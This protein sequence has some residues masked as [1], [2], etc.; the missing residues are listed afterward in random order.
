MCIVCKTPLA[1]SQSPEAERERTFISGLIAKGE[2]KA[3]ILKA[4]VVQYGPAVLA[5]PP[6]HGFNLTIYV[7]PAGAA[8]H[9]R[10]D[11]A[12]SRSHGGAGEREPPTATRPTPPS[13]R[14]R[15][16]TRTGSKKT[17]PGT[18]ANTCYIDVRR[19]DAEQP[20]RQRDR[21]LRRRRQRDPE[22]LDRL[23]RR[24]D[25]V[26][27][28]VE[29]REVLRELE[30]VRRDPVRRAPVGR[31][32]DLVRERSQLHH[33]RPLGRGGARRRPSRRPPTSA[34]V[35]ARSVENLRS[36]DAIRACAYWM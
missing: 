20:E 25:D 27:V 33:E 36:I 4:M 29:R 9:R 5:L 12:S 6:A 22:R 28:A 13:P 14:S 34:A 35:D 2:T 30:R 1:V 23:R 3:Q 15:P 17:S 16:R 19:A 7:L 8:D 26:A 32:G 21:P 18:G 11:P 10:G 24:A 31:L